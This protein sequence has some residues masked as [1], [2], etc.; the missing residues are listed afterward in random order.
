[1]ATTHVV[2]SRTVLR[3]ASA[4]AIGIHCRINLAA[5]SAMLRLLLFVP[6]ASPQMHAMHTGT[7]PKYLSVMRFTG[8]RQRCHARRGMGNRQASC[9]RQDPAGAGSRLEEA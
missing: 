6:A 2:L 4:L 8:L 7:A 1:M 5:P 3:R 9:Q